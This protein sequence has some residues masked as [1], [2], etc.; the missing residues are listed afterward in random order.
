MMSSSDTQR[1][2][3]AVFG[4]AFGFFVDMYDVYL[5]TVALVPAMDYFLPAN[6]PT[7]TRAVASALIFVA[8]LLGRPVG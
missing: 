2:R 3:R 8:T 7:D 1:T 5:P 4:A 6:M